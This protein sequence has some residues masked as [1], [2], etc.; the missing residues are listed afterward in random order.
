MRPGNIDIEEVTDATDWL[1]VENYRK[2][3]ANAGLSPAMAK[4]LALE[5]GETDKLCEYA[6]RQLLDLVFQVFGD[7]EVLD[8]YDEAK[9]HQ[10]DTETE[11]KRFETELEASRTN[12][13]GLRLRVANYHQWED[14]HK[15]RRNLLEEVLPSLE[16]HEAREKAGNVSRQLR[17]AR[18]PMAQ[19]DGVLTEKRNALAGQMRVLTEAQQQETLLEQESSVLSSRLGQINS[20]LK[21]LDSLLEQRERLHK[22]AADAGA[23]IAEVALKLDEK[24]AELARQRQ[25]RTAL[26]TRIAGEVATISALQGK[27]AMPEPDAVRGMRRSLR[28][29]GIAHAMLS[30]IVEVTDAKWQGAIEGILGGYASVVLLERAKDA[31]AAYR[32]AEQERYRH[33]IVPECVEAPQSKDASLLSV[34]KFS[35]AVPSWLIDQLARIDRV[36]S[37]EAGFKLSKDAEWITPDAYHRERRG[38]RSL[39]V[40]ASRYRFGQAGAHPASGR[41]AEVLAGAGSAGR[42]AHALDQQTGQRGGRPQGPHRRRGRSQGTGGASGRV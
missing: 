30:D 16:Y 18:R 42:C 37:V 14:M 15:E 26:T 6:P 8:A 40:E 22:L 13:E 10:R 2:R 21:P 4:V 11:L 17:E 39:F 29:A 23:D 31:P 28:D 41:A 35:A 19:A 32:L 3:L 9:R 34:V 1:G 27:S 24:E 12:L 7:K 36:D 5:Q 20:K 25:A 38:G 33:F